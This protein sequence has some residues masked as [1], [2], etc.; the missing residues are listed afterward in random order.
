MPTYLKP[1]TGTLDHIEEVWYCQGPRESPC[2]EWDVTVIGVN[3][4]DGAMA[5]LAQPGVKPMV[6]FRTFSDFSYYV[7]DF[8]VT[9]GVLWGI[10]RHQGDCLRDLDDPNA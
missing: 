8:I 1:F 9:D 5:E 7:S 6:V 10:I 3:P 4:S 2:E